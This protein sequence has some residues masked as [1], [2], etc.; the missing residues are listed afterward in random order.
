[1]MRRGSSFVFFV[2]W[3]LSPLTAW[4]D[5]FVNLPLAYLIANLVYAIVPADFKWLFIGSYIFTNIIGFALM[6]IAGKDFVLTKENKVKALASLAFN[7]AL[8]SAIIILLDK[9]G[10]LG[11]IS[12]YISG[13]FRG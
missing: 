8:F 6:F 4:N 3:L 5:S 13:C 2:G 11:P 10:A 7:T 12:R 1:M 9:S